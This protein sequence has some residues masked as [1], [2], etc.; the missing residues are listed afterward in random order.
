MS[1]TLVLYIFAG[2]LAKGDSVSVTHIP[3]FKSEAHCSAAGS[4]TK[5]LVSGSTKELRF[6]CI[7][8][9]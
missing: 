4:A 5:P 9:E 2:V 1:W 8:Q 3:N 7:R 6:V